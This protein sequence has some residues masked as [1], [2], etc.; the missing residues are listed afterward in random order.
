MTTDRDTLESRPRPQDVAEARAEVHKVLSQVNHLEWL[1][2]LV[3]IVRSFASIDQPT[4]TR[5]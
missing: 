3:I 5:Q 1:R 4:P 2:A